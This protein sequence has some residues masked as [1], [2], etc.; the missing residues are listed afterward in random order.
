MTIVDDDIWIGFL[1]RDDPK[2]FTSA[3]HNFPK[4]DRTL[5]IAVPKQAKAEERIRYPFRKEHPSNASRN[6]GESI[7]HTSND[8]VL[9]DRRTIAEG[10]STRRWQ[11]ISFVEKLC[12]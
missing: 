2:T 4:E 9:E 6:A 7:P 1:I 10:R 11:V 3:S 8:N 5:Q 12:W